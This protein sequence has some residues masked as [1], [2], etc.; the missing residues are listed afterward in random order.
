[1]EFTYDMS[2]DYRPIP[3]GERTLPSVTAEKFFLVHRDRPKRLEGTF[4]DERGDMYFTSNYTGRVYKLD[5]DALELRCVFEDGALRPA[6]VKVR[7]GRFI[8]PCLAGEK[9]GRIVVARQDGSTER[10][11]AEGRDVDD[12]V[13]DQNGNMYYTHFTGT[14][15]NPDGAVYR[16]TPD[17][18]HEEVFI[19]HLCG[20]NGICFSPDY[21]VMWITEFT[22]GRLLRI[23]MNNPGLGC[24]VYHFTGYFGPDSC[25]V[26]ADGNVYVCMFNQGRIMV[27]NPDGYPIG[28]ILMPNRD[29]GHNLNGAHA[30]IRPG[31]REC[32]IACSDDNGNEGSWIMKAP[33]MAPGLRPCL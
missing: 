26:D 2:R 4:F 1:M 24:V 8:I 5:M 10:V 7:D 3:P 13:F 18:E 29:V 32:Y 17:F 9:S 6:S 19:P 11:L 31:I 16:V 30:A 22:A 27:F 25:E 12:V 14:V 33:A 28:Q 20:P 23:P 21:S 15:Y